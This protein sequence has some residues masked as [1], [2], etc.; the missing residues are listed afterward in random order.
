MNFV[1]MRI[2]FVSS[3]V[4]DSACQKIPSAA[5][6]TPMQ[7]ARRVMPRRSG[8]RFMEVLTT[9]RILAS[10]PAGM[11]MTSAAVV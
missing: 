9:L 2:C 6:Q 7:Q 10:R 4:S 8:F 3:T 11:A 1:R 5:M